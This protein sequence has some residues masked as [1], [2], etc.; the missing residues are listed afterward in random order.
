MADAMHYE[1]MDLFYL[2]REMDADTG[3]ETI[4]S[5]PSK[6]LPSKKIFFIFLFSFTKQKKIGAQYTPIFVHHLSAYF[7]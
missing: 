2:G 1:Q 3:K 6:R 5:K 7:S 4:V